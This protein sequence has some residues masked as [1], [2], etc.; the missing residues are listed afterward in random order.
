VKTF[1]QFIAERTLYHGT[2]VD[3]EDSIRQIGLFG[4][5]G[6][7]QSSA[8]Y[9]DEETYGEPPR[10]EDEVVYMTDKQNLGRAVGAMVH[11]IGKKLGKGFHDVTDNDIRNHGLLCIMHDM[12]GPKDSKYPNVDQRPE[13]DRY[14]NQP[15]GAEPDDYYASSAKPDKMIKGAAL[16]R[17]LKRYGEWPRDWGEEGYYDRNRHFRGKILAKTVA[18]IKKVPLLGTFLKDLMKDRAIEDLKKYPLRTQRQNP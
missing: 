14:G 15:R 13:E 16:I 1:K 4:Q 3:N 5:M 9:D 2:I 18:D 12:E 6:D 8:G 17:L 10:E 11:H 7:F